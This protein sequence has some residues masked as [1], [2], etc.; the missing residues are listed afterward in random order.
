M[1][2]V[3]HKLGK[4][5]I[6]PA[7]IAGQLVGDVDSTPNASTRTHSNINVGS[8]NSGKI[9]IVALTHKNDTPGVASYNT[10]TLG[11]VNV[12]D[13]LVFNYGY[14]GP[15]YY[16]YTE[17]FAASISGLTGSQAF[18]VIMSAVVD[19]SVLTAIA[20]DNI[21]SATAVM[22]AVDLLRSSDPPATTLTA[23]GVYCPAGGI[24]FGA[25]T[26]SDRT[27]T[28]SWSSLTEQADLQS[29]ASADDHRHTAAWAIGGRA[30]ADE[31]LT[32]SSS[33]NLSSLIVASFR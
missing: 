3:I 30:A 10:L 22:Y 14:T 26:A 13:G 1:S 29:G 27:L 23:S 25:A 16:G 6:L 24:V 8:A 17:V 15:T 9:I 19:S 21:T 31:T 4:G 5:T 11:G 32:W 33:N 2:R 28:A 18:T 12:G 20:V 7:S